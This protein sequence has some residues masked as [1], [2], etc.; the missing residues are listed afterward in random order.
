MADGT[1]PRLSAALVERFATGEGLDRL[2]EAGRP[3]EK[4][5]LRR[6]AW[7]RLLGVVTGDEVS[8]WVKELHARRS[9]FQQIIEQH[10]S[11]LDVKKFDANI[12]NPLSRNSANPFLKIQAHEELQQEI[13]KDIERTY[14]EVDLLQRQDCRRSMQKVLFHWCKANNPATDASDSYRQGMNE[15]VAVIHY[16]V[17]CGEF[18]GTDALGE[19]L[20]GAVHTEADTFAL[21]SCLMEAGLRDMF[22][23]ERGAAM[24]KSDPKKASTLGELPL[25][26]G[27]RH[28]NTP[29]PQQPQ[30]AILARC[31]FIYDVLLKTID[32]PV[33]RILESNG[34]APQIFLLRWLRLLFCREFQLDETLVL[35]DGL[36]IDMFKAPGLGAFEYVG[37][38]AS[39]D[40][41]RAASAAMPLVDFVAVSMVRSLRHELLRSDESECM[42]LLLKFPPVRDVRIFSSMAARLRS[43]DT[44]AG[45]AP[46]SSP[47]AAGDASPGVGWGPS[48]F[49]PLPSNQ[50]GAETPGAPSAARPLGAQPCGQPSPPPGAPLSAPPLAAPQ[51]HAAAATGFHAPAVASAGQEGDPGGGGARLFGE[52]T[53]SLLDAGRQALDVAQQKITSIRDPAFAVGSGPARS[54]DDSEVIELRQRLAA[55]EKLAEH[56]KKKASEFLK[57]KSDEWSRKAQ[58]FEQRITDRDAKVKE[59]EDRMQVLAG[60]DAASRPPEVAGGVEADGHHRLEDL[61]HRLREATERIASLESS[62]DEALQR[63]ARAEAVA[64]DVRQQV[65]AANESVRLASERAT[66]AEQRASD[67]TAAMDKA[68]RKAAEAEAMVKTVTSESDSEIATLLAG[69]TEAESRAAS[70]SSAMEEQR[71]RLDEVGSRASKLQ[72]RVHE[73]ENSLQEASE[74]RDAAV[75]TVA[76]A[77]GAS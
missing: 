42:T 5:V 21:F 65:A 77:D 2:L 49:P 3:D 53:K 39:I 67:A 1:F 31:T 23:V 50:A 43:G 70:A 10:R 4:H 12:C 41:A 62:N 35:W 58:D 6:L 60:M 66:T 44:V 54:V 34:V 38:G 32:E 47:S 76:G 55:A 30:S 51:Q 71:A 57:I 28:A 16:V 72:E 75:A 11:E 17:R 63:A 18:S 13:W 68:L 27:Q 48:L 29:P 45:I 46:G 26:R 64:A 69:K 7:V 61:E 25:V 36:F 24:Q 37:K 8:E 22:A 20:C 14:P 33:H 73:L 56:V 52:A 19:D 15:L 74:E 59:L 9:D 40:V